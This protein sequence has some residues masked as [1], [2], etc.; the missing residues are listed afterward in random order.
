MLRVAVFLD[1]ANVNSASLSSFCKVNYKALLE[2][3]ADYDEGRNL[4]VAYAYVP[5]DPRREHAMD[6][7]ITMLWDSGYIVRSKVGVIAGNTYKC[8]FDIEMTLDIVKTSFEIKPDIVV[9]VSGDSD[10]IPV[11]TELREKGIRV[12]VA[13]FDQSMSQL[14]SNRCSGRILLDELIEEGNGHYSLADD[15]QNEIEKECE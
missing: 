9:I 14:L 15:V 12:E 3:L 11:V 6:D 8:N 2:Y 13:S 1:Y 4:T 7:E 10:F 5:I